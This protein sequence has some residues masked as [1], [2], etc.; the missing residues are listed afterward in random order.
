MFVLVLRYSTC[1]CTPRKRVYD[2][3]RV[4]MILCVSL[5]FHS[6]NCNICMRILSRIHVSQ[7]IR[8]LRAY[9]LAGCG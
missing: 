7:L 6:A 4:S 2:R 5:V 8:A 3:K 1:L 9:S